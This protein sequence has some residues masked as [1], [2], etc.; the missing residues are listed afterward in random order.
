MHLHSLSEAGRGQLGEERGTNA[1]HFGGYRLGSALYQSPKC[2]KKAMA[3]NPG[4]IVWQV[5]GKGCVCVGGGEGS[6]LWDQ[7]ESHLAGPQPSPAPFI[8]DLGSWERVLESAS[9]L[10]LGAQYPQ[11]GVPEPLGRLAEMDQDWVL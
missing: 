5:P 9:N 3:P 8:Q 1:L 4:L 10:S 7:T 6:V 11:S 2:R